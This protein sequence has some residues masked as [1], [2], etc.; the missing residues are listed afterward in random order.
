[1][2][3]RQ[4]VDQVTDQPHDYH[5]AV[6][7]PVHT[8]QNWRSPDIGKAHILHLP[9]GQKVVRQDAGQYMALTGVGLPIVHE[10]RPSWHETPVQALEAVRSRSGY[11]A[12]LEHPSVRSF[13]QA[14]K[15]ADRKSKNKP[16]KT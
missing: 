7:H 15:D 3:K 13:L 16:E 8:R 5:V 12:D 4:H 11:T 9:G 6:A 10:G 2:K 1:M 14:C